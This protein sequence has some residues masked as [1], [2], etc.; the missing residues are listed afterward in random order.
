MNC[1]T[2]HKKHALCVK[3][4][5]K[6]KIVRYSEASEMHFKSSHVDSTFVGYELI[7]YHT[8][9]NINTIMC[10]YSVFVYTCTQ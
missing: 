10:D 2:M 8:H 6:F 3:M 5:G 1:I 9:R 7:Y 4:W